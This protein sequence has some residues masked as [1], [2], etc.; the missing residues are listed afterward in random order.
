MPHIAVK[1]ASNYMW[2]LFVPIKWGD[3][4]GNFKRGPP[5]DI[6]GVTPTSNSPS[7]K[8]IGEA[9]YFEM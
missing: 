5:N 4:H 1:L 7:V 8:L 3:F 6:L 9:G 2:S